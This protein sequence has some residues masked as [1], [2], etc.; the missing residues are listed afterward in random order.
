MDTRSRKNGLLLTEW[1]EKKRACAIRLIGNC[2]RYR[3]TR[4]CERGNY[5]LIELP[6]TPFFH[7]EI[8]FDCRDVTSNFRLR[9]SNRK[10]CKPPRSLEISPTRTRERKNPSRSRVKSTPPRWHPEMPKITQSGP[11][12][13]STKQQV[14]SPDNKRFPRSPSSQSVPE[15][16]DRLRG[17]AM[18]AVS[19]S[20]Y[21]EGGGETLAH[22]GNPECS[23]AEHSRAPVSSARAI[24][25]KLFTARFPS[26]CIGPFFRY[27]ALERLPE[28][29]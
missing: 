6:C 24:L 22:N 3:W 17:M 10:T 26:V 25:P 23:F 14:Q 29:C 11:T 19:F 20:L 1:R 28:T 8:G 18:P 4:R 13:S 9:E 7:S 21:W 12:W 16:V 5:R 27:L 2:N 15:S